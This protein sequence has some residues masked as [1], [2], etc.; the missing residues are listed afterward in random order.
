ML[1]ALLEAGDPVPG[2]IYKGFSLMRLPFRRRV[3]KAYAIIPDC[4]EC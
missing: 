4:D 1:E 3:T 2:G